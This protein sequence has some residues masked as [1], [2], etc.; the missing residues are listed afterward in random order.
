MAERTTHLLSATPI[1]V[2][3]SMSKMITYFYNHY[4]EREWDTACALLSNKT[5]EHFTKQCTILNVS[6]GICY[7]CGVYPAIYFDEPH[8]VYGAFAVV[9]ILG[10]Y[11]AF[12]EDRMLWRITIGNRIDID[13]AHEIYRGHWLDS[14]RFFVDVLDIRYFL[15]DGLRRG[16]GPSTKLNTVK[17]LV[18][19]FP[20][21]MSI[22]DRDGLTS[23]FELA[24]QFASAD[25]VQYMVELDDKLVTL[26]D[27]R[28]D[29]PL[30]WACRRR[31]P[32]SLKVVNYLLEKQMSLVTKTNMG[33]DLPIHLASDT[34][35]TDGERPE[36]IEI[37]LRLLLAYPECLN[38]VWGDTS[39]NETDMHNKKNR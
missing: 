24:C 39:S 38:C 35:K 11:M 18:E 17:A 37:V 25:I 22:L 30:H 34:V 7:F 12:E 4:L 19:M 21:Y 20:A 32:G 2:I 6:I 31:A 3:I 15:C 36:R 27:E 28:G 5:K 16:L 33:G 29:S 23:P 26:C 8:V 1:I 13:R 10:S 9:G 14:Y